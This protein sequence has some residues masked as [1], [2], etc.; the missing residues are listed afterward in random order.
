MRIK[1]W[2]IRKWEKIQKKQK[3]KLL[4]KITLKQKHN[5]NTIDSFTFSTYGII[6]FIEFRY[7]EQQIVQIEYNIHTIWNL[8][9]DEVVVIWS[10]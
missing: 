4:I 7:N 10:F 9:V 1:S 3:W 2:K 5:N 8:L 6:I